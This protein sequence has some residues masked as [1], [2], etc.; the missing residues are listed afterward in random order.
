MT[1]GDKGRGRV[2]RGG[3][4]GRQALGQPWAARAGGREK[5]LGAR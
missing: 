2:A 5:W 3:G 1:N 4:R